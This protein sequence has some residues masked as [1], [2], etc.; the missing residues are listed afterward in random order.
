MAPCGAPPSH[1]PHSL[2][3]TPN[4]PTNPFDASNLFA[5]CVAAAQRELMRNSPMAPQPL[6]G[7]IWLPC[8]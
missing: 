4:F 1:T 2:P 3:A 6:D 7:Y 5:K 8:K